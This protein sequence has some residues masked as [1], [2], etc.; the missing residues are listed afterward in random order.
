MAKAVLLHMVHGAFH[1]VF[2]AIQHV[3]VCKGQKIHAAVPQ[4][5]Q[6]RVGSIEPGIAGTGDIAIPADRSFQVSHGEVGVRQMTRD[7][8]KLVV[9]VVAAVYRAGQLATAEHDVA[10]RPH[11]RAAQR[12]AR[13]TREG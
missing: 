5:G 11:A 8:F 12:T 1:A 7:H 6:G 4:R 9:E 10:H 13:T 3:I 2:P